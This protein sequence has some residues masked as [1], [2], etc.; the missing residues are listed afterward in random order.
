MKKAFKYGFMFIAFG[1]VV[2][3]AGILIH[4]KVTDERLE[5]YDWLIP[6]YTT[7]EPL[8]WSASAFVA[9]LSLLYT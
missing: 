6:T 7:A 4:S 8:I 9:S 2:Q 3:V 5:G 1:N